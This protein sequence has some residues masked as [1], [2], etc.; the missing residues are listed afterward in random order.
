M[1]TVLRPFLATVFGEKMSRNVF[2]PGFIILLF[3][4][5]IVSQDLKIGDAVGSP[6]L[7]PDSRYNKDVGSINSNYNRIGT[8]V[9]QA[10][11]SGDEEIM[12]NPD[13][14]HQSEAFDRYIYER[15]LPATPAS[16]LTPIIK[17][18]NMVL[19]EGDPSYQ[20]LPVG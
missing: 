16:S 10:Y 12:L 19:W 8:D 17:N 14:Y 6:I 15:V 18:I 11:F 7:W 2:L 5:F 1:P 3:G 13:L 9:L 4:G 20:L